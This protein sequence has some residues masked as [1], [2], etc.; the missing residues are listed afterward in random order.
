MYK[1]KIVLLLFV[2]Y[3]CGTSKK[4]SDLKSADC[5]DY[6][7]GMIEAK[8]ILNDE[9]KSL[10]E[11]QGIFIQEF[12]FENVYQGV[13]RKSWN[14]KKLNA[15][16]IR[17]L[18]TYN[19]EDKISEGVQLKD[20]NNDNTVCN[21]IVQSFVDLNEKEFSSFGKLINYNNKFYRLETQ[22]KY[23]SEIAMHPCVKHVSIMKSLDVPDLKN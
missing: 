16:P 21:L 17:K 9:E 3:S 4:V 18:R 14:K 15:T 7:F 2:I 23:I 20:L 22:K 12:L 11:K 19:A 10:L 13:W 8:R 5:I 6:S 1:L